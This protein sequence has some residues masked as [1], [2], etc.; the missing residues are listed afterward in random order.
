VIDVEILAQ[1]KTLIKALLIT[2]CIAGPASAITISVADAG[3]SYE[4]TVPTIAERVLA[5]EKEVK[6]RA[7]QSEQALNKATQAME[8]RLDGMNEFRDTLKDQA[9]TFV[10]RAEMLAVSGIVA[11]I[12]SIFITIVLNIF[13]VWKVKA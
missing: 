4:P 9:G 10:T 1:M 8:K 7:E 13:N 3:W 11:T 12:V 5:L 2:L 6:L